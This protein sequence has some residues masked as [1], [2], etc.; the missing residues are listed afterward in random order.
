VTT[1]ATG[2]RSF[3]E[4]EKRRIVDETSQAG[5]SVAQ[6]ARRYGIAPRVLFRW[7]EAFKPEAEPAAPAFAPVQIM[8]AAPMVEAPTAASLPVIV[9]RLAPGIEVELVG[10]RRVRFER[11]ADPETVRRLVALL[12]G[13]AS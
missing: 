8:D 6:V 2:R 7:K 5:M 1:G 4:V 3:S 12:E 9:E 11:D 10:G 13:G